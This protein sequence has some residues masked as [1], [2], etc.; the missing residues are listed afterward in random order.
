MITPFRGRTL[1][2]DSPVEMY[3]CLNRK[4]YTFSLRQGTLVVGHTDHVM[5]KHCE[6]MVKEAGRSRCITSGD[7]NVHAWIKGY[8]V[9]EPV[10]PMEFKHELVYTPFNT[11]GFTAITVSSTIENLEKADIVSV[12]NGKVKVKI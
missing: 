1:D 9:T 11:S 2:Y 8:I 5:L 12:I 3:R 6:F 10:D 4:G 7:R